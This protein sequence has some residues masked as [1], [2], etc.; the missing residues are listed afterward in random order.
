MTCGGIDREYRFGNGLSR[1]QRLKSEPQES[2]DDEFHGKDLSGTGMDSSRAV[3]DDV[4]QQL[5][6]SRG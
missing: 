1:A 5:N 2:D 6:R 3:F 4:D